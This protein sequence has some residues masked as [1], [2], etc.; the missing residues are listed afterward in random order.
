MQRGQGRPHLEVGL[1]QA[2]KGHL[3]V[4]GWRGV[5][6]GW[7]GREEGDALSGHNWSSI[8]VCRQN[9]ENG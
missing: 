3:R 8:S 9:I 7:T 2:A 1:L 4:G 6:G 5:D